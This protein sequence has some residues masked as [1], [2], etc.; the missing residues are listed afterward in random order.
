M[1]DAIPHNIY[2]ERRFDKENRE[3]DKQGSMG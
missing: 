3:F 2:N 1:F